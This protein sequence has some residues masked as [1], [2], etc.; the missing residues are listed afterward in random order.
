M[1]IASAL[2]ELGKKR[3][4]LAIHDVSFPSDSDE[5]IGRGAP[6]T[7]AAA[8]L[9]AYVRALGFTGVQLGPQGQTS[10]DNPSPYDS[11]IFSRHTSTIALSS[12]RPGGQYAR[13]VDERL[14]DQLVVAG[15]TD[16]RHAYDASH[17]LVAM[18]FARLEED[19]AVVERFAAFIAA[20]QRWLGEDA[21]YAA[22]CK[23]HGG[24]GHR[25][26]P[27]IDRADR[28]FM[29]KNASELTRYAFGQF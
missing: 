9:F 27:V 14:L 15:P 24:V 13:L 10:R 21:L 8:R 7:N 29:M 6:T 5:D 17:R 1:S 23:S 12:F 26:W 16:H 28:S 25:D 20:H 18:A 4:L 19:P 2:R 11:T 22:Y 3:L